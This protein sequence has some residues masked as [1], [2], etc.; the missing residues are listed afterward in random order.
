[1]AAP[2]PAAATPTGVSEAL[3]VLGKL[4]PGAELFTYA[5]Q[6][7]TDIS[8]AIELAAAQLGSPR[9][10]QGADVQ[11]TIARASGETAVTASGRIDPNARGTLVRVRVPAAYGAG[12]WRAIVKVAGTPGLDDR[13]DVRT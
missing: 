8:V 12:P 4:Q 1:P 11:I 6:E 13:A 2:A 7:G 10:A 5:T 9:W 3:G